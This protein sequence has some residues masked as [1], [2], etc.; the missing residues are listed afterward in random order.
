MR[1]VFLVVIWSEFHK[2]QYRDDDHRED[3]SHSMSWVLKFLE[4]VLERL[5]TCLIKT[6]TCCSISVF[7]LFILFSKSCHVISSGFA[8]LVVEVDPVVA[9]AAALKIII[10]V[11][12]RSHVFPIA[13]V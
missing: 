6:D 11:G 3:A 8:A 9:V 1:R 5:A 12:Q 10:L 2:G 13:G 4:W 7:H